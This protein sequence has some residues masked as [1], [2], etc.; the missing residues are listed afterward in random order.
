ML[1]VCLVYVC[2]KITNNKLYLLIFREFV[3]V[4]IGRKHPP[5]ADEER[6]HQSSGRERTDENGDVQEC[7]ALF[8]L[9]D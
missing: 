6:A 7:R 2:R 5:A 4:I 1:L 9:V 8:R 3:L